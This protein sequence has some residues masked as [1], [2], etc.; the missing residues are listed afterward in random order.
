MK[1][2]LLVLNLLLLAAVGYLYYRQFVS[3][4]NKNFIEISGHKDQNSHHA[5]FRIAYFEI[6]SIETYFDLV[7]EIRNEISRKQAAINLEMERLERSYQNKYN[8]YQAQISAMSEAQSEKATLEL[9]KT[10]EN[11]KNRK[12][13][14]ERDYNDYVTRRMQEVKSKIEEFL[15]EYNKGKGYSFIM[16]YEP[17]L[18]YYRDTLYNITADVVKGLNERYGKKK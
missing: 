12:M 11:I 18:L 10:Q 17:G 7:K 3:A 9:M 6:D 14:L 5:P 4:S 13:E 8:E 2:A 16:A 15:K 1:N